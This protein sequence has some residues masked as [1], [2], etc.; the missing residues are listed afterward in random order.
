MVVVSVLASS[1]VAWL[2]DKCIFNSA[3]SFPLGKMSK[4]SFAF[5]DRAPYWLSLACQARLQRDKHDIGS[6]SRIKIDKPVP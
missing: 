5:F 1:C 6:L 2:E 4:D 3:C